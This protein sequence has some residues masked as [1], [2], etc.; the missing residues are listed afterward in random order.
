VAGKPAARRDAANPQNNTNDWMRDRKAQLQAQQQ[1][2]A[3]G[4]QA[5][6]SST[7][8]GE[9]LQAPQPA[10][11]L[12]LGNRDAQT[13]SAAAD[14][15]GASPSPI[16]A[17][18]DAFSNFQNG[19]AI[20]RPNLAESFIPV[21]GPGWDAVA[22]LQQ[23]NYGGAALNGALA[24]SDLFLA[25]S[26]AKGIAKGGI[27]VAGKATT[28]AAPYAWR[29]MRPRMQEK[30]FIKAGEEGHHWAIPQNQWGKEVPEWLKNQAW[31]IKSLD[32]VTHARLRN[33]IGD[34]PRFG[35]LDRLRY[36]TPA[37]AK[38]VA[39]SAAGHSVSTVGASSDDN[40]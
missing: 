11:V 12:A 15:T 5:W 38:A 4:R 35:P 18:S 30:G 34:L 8:T 32:S 27:Y 26:I 36:G 23:G 33:K 40:Q 28:R 25:G 22:D 29:Y 7:R 31:N 24:A 1:A 13:P 14:G 39:G 17:V 20:P 2:E 10:D 19:P 21:V 6:V 9:N 37:W 16:Q 3:A